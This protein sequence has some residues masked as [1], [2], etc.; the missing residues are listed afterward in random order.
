MK[1]L[2]Y[3]I[4]SKITTGETKIYYKNKL[5]KLVKNRTNDCLECIRYMDE[6]I[7]KQNIYMDK[8]IKTQETHIM[9]I[10]EKKSLQIEE[11]YKLIK[12]LNELIKNKT[13]QDK[14]QL[15]T[16]AKELI[17][18]LKLNSK[19]FNGYQYKYMDKDLVIVGTGPTL[20]Y[21][22]QISDAIHIGLNKAFSAENVVLDFLFMQDY[23]ACSSYIDTSLNYK[24]K[25]LIRFYGYIWPEAFEDI[26]VPC[27]TV[28]KHKAEAFYSSCK[29]VKENLFNDEKIF[30]LDLEN[31]VLNAS[32]GVAMLGIQFALY[33]HPKKI[34]IVGCDCG[35][36]YADKSLQTTPVI[37]KTL[38]SMV[39]NW[40][41]L[42]KF[43]DKYYPDVEIISVNPVGLKG[44]F[45]DVYTKEYLKD[46]PEI[47]PDEVEILEV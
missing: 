28:A 14:H 24:N 33:T 46:H 41:Q 21:Y 12:E 2:K 30:A 5:Q 19:T 15:I 38:N 10:F 18:I 7:K 16:Y 4:L 40:K 43:A 8:L 31:E 36:G 1:K 35:G 3:K 37:E 39:Y 11:N 20:N 34:Y 27:S 42:K 44:V 13:E 32:G 25:N 17:K 45:K 22:K 26:T 9:E 23:R 6:L 29:M 47:N